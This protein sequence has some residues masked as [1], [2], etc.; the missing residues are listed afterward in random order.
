MALILSG[1]GLTINYAGRSY[2]ELRADFFALIARDFPQWTDTSPY[3]PGVMIA[4]YQARIGQFLGFYIN[5]RA[6][7][8][9]IST[10]RSE[11]SARN[12]GKLFGYIPA[13]PTT[14]TVDITVTTKSGGTIPRL[15][16]VSSDP[17][18][19]QASLKYELLDTFVAPAAGQYVLSFSHGETRENTVIG[20]GNGIPFQEITL[21]DKPVATNANGYPEFELDVLE[22]ADWVRWTRVSNFVQSSATS[23]HYVVD[24][25][26][27]DELVVKCGDGVT[28]KIWPMSTSISNIRATYR[29][30]GGAI[31]S[32]PGRGSI[33]NIANARGSTIVSSVINLREPSGGKDKETLEQTKQNLPLAAAARDSIVQFD[34]A[35]SEILNSGLGVSRI[36][37][38]RGAGPYEIVVT[39]AAAG[40][41]PK[42]SGYWD[43]FSQSGEGLIGAVGSFITARCS[44][45]WVLKVLSAIPVPVVASLLIT[46]AS[47]AYR[48][49]VEARVRAAYTEFMN[50]DT[51]EF[52]DKVRITEVGQLLENLSG[53]EY[54]EVLKFYRVPRAVFKNGNDTATF[55]AYSIAEHVRDEIWTVRF[56]DNVR[57]KVIGSKSGEQKTVGVANNNRPY[58][59][60]NGCL[61]FRCTT[62]TSNPPSVGTTY[63]MRT[64]EYVGTITADEQ[65][66]ITAGST[67]ISV[68]GGVS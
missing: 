40:G 35:V 30:G 19:D 20:R 31:G 49:D 64:S 4:G 58:S 7:E 32:R 1:D 54:A 25:N 28:G 50:S 56:L 62:N 48:R 16:T 60:D 22:G 43:S 6:E 45:S 37:L 42:P 13:R 23:K 55:S 66:I 8:A 2:T 12:I 63:T 51:Q 39:V 68:T 24:Y 36:R 10:L 33:R 18:T 17:S 61:S 34:D 47:W 29:I 57:F 38:A 59:V 14:A 15:F 65:E 67:S 9:Y 53:V 11:T 5:R 3:D 27:R 41:S 21:Y 44:E 46:C 26:D 52:G